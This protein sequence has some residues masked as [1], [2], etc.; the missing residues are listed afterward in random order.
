MEPAQNLYKIPPIKTKTKKLGGGRVIEKISS[1]EDATQEKKIATEKVRFVSKHITI[2]KK[3]IKTSKDGVCSGKIG[4]DN[5]R[6]K[7][8]WRAQE[9]SRK[10]SEP[11]IDKKTIWK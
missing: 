8:G 7:T 3:I 6:T 11:T 9:G 5:R 2:K 10:Q 4:Q 1:S